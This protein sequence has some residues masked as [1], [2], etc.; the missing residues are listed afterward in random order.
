MNADKRKLKIQKL[1][2]LICVHRRLE[3]RFPCPAGM[4]PAPVAGMKQERADPRIGYSVGVMPVL[5]I[6]KKPV[7]DGTRAG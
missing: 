3:K 7:P 5:A 1:S 4:Q 2:A 6:P